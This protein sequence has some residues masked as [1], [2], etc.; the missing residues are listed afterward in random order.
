MCYIPISGDNN[1]H[2]PKVLQLPPGDTCFKILSVI[3]TGRKVNRDDLVSVETRP[4]A[5]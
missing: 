3:G 4:Q 1:I 5:G 2:K